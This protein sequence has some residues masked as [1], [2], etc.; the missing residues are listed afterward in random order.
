MSI[1]TIDLPLDLCLDPEEQF[2]HRGR[3]FGYKQRNKKYHW[4]MLGIG[5]QV[6]NQ[7]LQTLFEHSMLIC[8]FCHHA[9][10]Q[11]QAVI[12]WHRSLSESYFCSHIWRSCI[13]RADASLLT[14]WQH[15]RVNV[16]IFWCSCRCNDPRG[17][18]GRD[19][20]CSDS[21]PPVV[22]SGAPTSL[23]WEGSLR[24]SLVGCADPHTGA[25]HLHGNIWFHRCDTF[26]PHR[27]HSGPHCEPHHLQCHWF[28]RPGLHGFSGR[29]PPLVHLLVL[30]PLSVPTSG[31]PWGRSRR[32][33]HAPAPRHTRYGPRIHILGP[34]FVS[35]LLNCILSTH[36]SLA[37]LL[38]WNS[39][40]ASAY[41]IC[42]WWV[43]DTGRWAVQANRMDACIQS[44]SAPNKPNTP[45]TLAFWL[46]GPKTCEF[47]SKM[48]WR[49]LV[50]TKLLLICKE[51]TCIFSIDN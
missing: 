47:W 44:R 11:L 23:R 43:M 24:Y 1:R 12:H 40:L 10:Q 49:P 50:S 45:E 9:L 22:R 26:R 2:R 16:S 28:A 21:V 14:D 8:S 38:R 48:D 33:C 46:Q 30:V 25:V 18:A 7:D 15:F 3:L 34:I 17:G 27:E 5:I 13:S 19:L 29:L 51:Q 41:V 37:A 35:M 31:P 20:D 6:G 36:V 4:N 42:W 39:V 32:L